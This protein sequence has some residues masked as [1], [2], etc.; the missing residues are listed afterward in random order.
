MEKTPQETGGNFFKSAGRDKWQR[1]FFVLM[2]TSPVRA[3]S[4]SLSPPLFSTLGAVLGWN[5]E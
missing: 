1:R 4:L 2:R 5:K 3:Y